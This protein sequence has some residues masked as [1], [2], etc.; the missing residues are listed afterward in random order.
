MKEGWRRV[1]ELILPPHRKLNFFKNTHSFIF[2]KSKEGVF[3]GLK[4]QGRRGIL[5]LILHQLRL[6]LICVLGQ[7]W[8]I[9]HNVEGWVCLMAF[10]RVHL[11]HCICLGVL[12]LSHCICPIAFV[13]LHLSRCIC[14]VAFVVLHLPCCICHVVIVKFHL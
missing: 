11:S 5:V 12:H 7:H 4:R 2:Q 14:P 6:E 13:P 9:F 8:V 1:S 10:V 3:R